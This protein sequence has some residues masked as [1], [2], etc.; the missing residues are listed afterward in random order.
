MAYRVI[1]KDLGLNLAFG[2]DVALEWELGRLA[3]CDS[4]DCG[5]GGEHA[6]RD[7]CCS[8]IFELRHD[9]G[10]RNYAFRGSDMD[11]EPLVR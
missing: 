5:C 9:T 7:F 6:T 2:R 1:D 4:A 8:P 10:A 11:A 3:R